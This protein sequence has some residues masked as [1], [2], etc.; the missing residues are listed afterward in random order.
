MMRPTVL[1]LAVCL[2]LFLPSPTVVQAQGL[3]ESLFGGG[4]A[5]PQRPQFSPSMRSRHML[6][7]QSQPW[8]LRSRQREK[9]RSRH[10]TAMCVRMCDG[11]Y[12]PLSHRARRG[13]FYKLARRCS[14]SCGSEAKLFYMPSS[15]DDVANMT[16]LSGRAYDQIDTA[17]LYR[18]KLVKSCTCKPMPWSHEARSKHAEYAAERAK[19]DG[20][21]RSK[22]QRVAALSGTP[23]GSKG[24]HRSIVESLDEDGLANGDG[25]TDET[26]SEAAAASVAKPRARRTKRKA[27]R[28]YRLR[29]GRVRVRRIPRHAYPQ[30]GP[31]VKYKY[32]K[33][34]HRV[35]YH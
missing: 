8:W 32:L 2:G 10:Y 30:P 9:S 11:Y 7:R 31:R 1:R 23:A 34:N 5:R 12:F 3:F 19:K 18:K 4:N 35:R 33:P 27:R 21:T 20:R 17:F 25:V 29:Y 28:K 24:Q 16:D 26:S 14:E 6:R 15:S 22:T 13:K